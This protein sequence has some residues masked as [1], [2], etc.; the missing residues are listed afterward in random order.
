M[1]LTIIH[2][3]SRSCMVDDQSVF[4]QPALVKPLLRLL[5]LGYVTILNCAYSTAH[6]RVYNS[7]LR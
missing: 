1:V 4:I 7:M 5:V 3:K 2:I 6:C